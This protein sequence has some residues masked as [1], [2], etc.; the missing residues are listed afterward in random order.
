M[1]VGQRKHEVA[2]ETQIGRQIR[3][4]RAMVITYLRADIGY[5]EAERE[6]AL[7]APH[8]RIRNIISGE[9]Y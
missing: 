2:S 7:V 6:L 5:V 1:I 3:I 4:I 8:H 9:V